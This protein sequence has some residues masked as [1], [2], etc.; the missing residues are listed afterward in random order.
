MQIPNLP[1]TMQIGKS[2]CTDAVLKELQLQL[3]TRKIVKVKLLKSALS[4]KQKKEM[5]EEIVQKTKA[6]LLHNVGFIIILEK[7]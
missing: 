7:R 1:V 5:I 6:K 4:Q 2:G 3:K